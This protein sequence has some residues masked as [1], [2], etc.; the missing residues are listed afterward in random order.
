M[1]TYFDGCQQVCL[2]CPTKS[3]HGLLFNDGAIGNRGVHV[4]TVTASARLTMECWTVYVETC[5][6]WVTTGYNRLATIGGGTRLIHKLPLLFELPSYK[7]IPEYSVL[8]HLSFTLFWL[9]NKHVSQ[10]KKQEVMN[11]SRSV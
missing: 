11:I 1:L 8:K 9:S 5:Q 6:N 4:C 10:L 3:Y 2:F 7:Y